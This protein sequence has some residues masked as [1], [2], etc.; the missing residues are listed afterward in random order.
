M[1]VRVYESML[2]V[3]MHAVCMQVLTE[4]KTGPRTLEAGAAGS[5]EAPDKGTRNQT[6]IFWKDSKC[7]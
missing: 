1:C 3:H 5:H 6:W 7:S 2:G 4:D